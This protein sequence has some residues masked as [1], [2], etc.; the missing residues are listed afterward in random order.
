[1]KAFSELPG[2]L[3]RIGESKDTARKV[4]KIEGAV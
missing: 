2:R 3:K 4:A 1:M